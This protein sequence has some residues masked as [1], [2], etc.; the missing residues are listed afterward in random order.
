VGVDHPG[1]HQE[2]RRVD[3]ASYDRQVG[4]Y[5]CHNSIADSYIDELPAGA[6]HNHS[7]FDSP[8]GHGS[9]RVRFR[10]ITYRIDDSTRKG[11]LVSKKAKLASIGVGRWAGF[12]ATALETGGE[13]EI[14]SC[15]ARTEELRSAFAQQHNCRAAGSLEELLA[16]PEVEGVLIATSHTSHRPLVEAA[17]AA[18]KQIFV[19][20]PLALGTEDG[21]ACVEAAAAAGVALQVG[22]QRRRASAN[23]RIK[24]MIEAGQLGELQALEANLSNPVGMRMPPGAWRRNEAESPLGSMTSLGVHHLDTMSYLAGP[25]RSVFARTRPGRQ[26]SIDEVSVLALEFES[27]AIGTLITS[28]YTPTVSRLAVFGSSGAAFN[29][30]DGAILKVQTVDQNVPVEVAID[31]ADPLVDQM[32]EFARVVRGEAK[33]ET[34]GVAGLAVVRLL[35]AAVQSS[36]TGRSVDI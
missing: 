22:H 21:M 6:G 3:Q 4:S 17:A 32:I 5:G 13:G 19:E 16:D 31:P 29:E 26:G 1:E 28:F 11:A 34:D 10:S 30:S 8:V 15:F 14:V 25:M 36:Q 20:K 12:L 2:A 35:E 27:G 23:R 24:A 33:P 18:G 7:A 9:S